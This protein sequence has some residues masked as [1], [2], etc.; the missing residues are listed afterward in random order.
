MK[1]KNKKKEGAQTP[2]TKKPKS[3]GLD[4]K[5]SDDFGQV[6]SQYSSEKNEIVST[7][8]KANEI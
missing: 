1:N 3:S 7:T 8:E 5:R 6:T 2:P 4:H